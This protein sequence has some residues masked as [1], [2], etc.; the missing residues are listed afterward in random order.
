MHVSFF[1]SLPVLVV[2]TVTFGSIREGLDLVKE[3]INR[4]GYNEKI[5]I[6]IDVAATDFCKGEEFLPPNG[7]TAKVACTIYI[8]SFFTLEA[9]NGA[10]SW[11]ENL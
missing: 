11:Y 5:K 9:S 3:A 8:V 7:R 6:A 10:I 1:F 2:H 4:T